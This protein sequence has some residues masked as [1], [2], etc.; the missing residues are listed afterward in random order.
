MELTTA[1]ILQIG[2]A[3]AG[4]DEGA[5]RDEDETTGHCD[6]PG[7]GLQRQ[8]VLRDMRHEPKSDGEDHDPDA[9]GQAAAPAIA[10]P[11][12]EGYHGDREGC[13]AR[14]TGQLPRKGAVMTDE[15]GHHDSGGGGGRGNAPMSKRGHAH[16]I[17]AIR[18]VSALH[19]Q[20]H[21]GL[22]HSCRASPDAGCSD[23]GP[24]AYSQEPRVHLRTGRLDKPG[25]FV[26]RLARPG[27]HIANVGVHGEPAA[28]HLEELWIKV[29]LTR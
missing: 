22:L 5:R 10:D 27:G 14:N 25:P 9:Q 29:V 1:T 28:L 6:R 8:N 4:G 24:G 11:R 23:H 3:P 26:P 18:R 21:P 7:E 19:R 20:C 2:A 13:D 15:H 12:L 16:D 17:N